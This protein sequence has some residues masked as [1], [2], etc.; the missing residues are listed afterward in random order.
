MSGWAPSVHQTRSLTQGGP[1]CPTK[2]EGYGDRPVEV[3]GFH[4]SLGCLLDRNL[5]FLAHYGDRGAKGQVKS[6]LPDPTATYPPTKDGPATAV[7]VGLQGA[8][9]T[10]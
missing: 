3:H 2:A 6:P 9:L 5:I 7:G 1:Q 8:H 10:G 4:H